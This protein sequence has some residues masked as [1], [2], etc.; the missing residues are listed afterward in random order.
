MVT[1][2]ALLLVACIWTLSSCTP[3]RA[4]VPSAALPERAAEAEVPAGARILEIDPDRSVVTMLVRRSGP[5]ARLG[6]NHVI[7][8]AQ[9][10]GRAWLGPDPRESG[11][12]IRLPV[13]AFVVDDPGARL[14]AGAEF[15]GE[16][17]A[18]AR[19]GTYRNM[20]RAEVLDGAGHPE[21]VVRAGRVSGTWQQPVVV[22]RITLRG[23]TRE[24]EVPV[25]LQRDA[26]SMLA[27]G[28]LR[29]RQSD[30]GITPFSVGG[31]AI[32]VADEVD[33]RFEIYSALVVSSSQVPSG[34]SSNAFSRE[35]IPRGS[36]SSSR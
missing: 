33:V 15:P 21:V 11:F 12:E 22:A 28:A 18:E 6:H 34:A 13:V 3:R 30:F 7:T 31:G 9:E 36:R 10:S 25:E 14:A 5:L 32:Q 4:E 20:L 2:R 24:I 35:F 8:S 19:E 29:I 1:Q 17:P 27:K 23:A 26:Q 16:L